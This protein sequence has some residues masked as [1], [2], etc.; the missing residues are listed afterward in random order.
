MIHIFVNENYS[1][2]TLGDLLNYIN[3]NVDRELTY[4]VNTDYDKDVVVE[5]DEP[6]NEEIALELSGIDTFKGDLCIIVEEQYC[7]AFLNGH[8]ALIRNYVERMI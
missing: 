1:K 4:G 8:P 7:K 2:E 5:T 3:I 6:K